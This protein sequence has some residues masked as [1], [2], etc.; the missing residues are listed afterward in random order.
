MKIKI[1]ELKKDWEQDYSDIRLGHRRSRL[2]EL[3]WLYGKTKDKYKGYESREDAK[4]LLQI[5]DHIKKE[6]DGDL[7]INGKIQ[8]DIEQTINLQIQIEMIK[9]FNITAFIIAKIAGKLNINPLFLMSRL[10]HSHYAKFTGFAAANKDEMTEAEIYSPTS[11]VYNWEE[12]VNS[13]TILVQRDKELMQLPS[14]SDAVIITEERN[15]EDVKGNIGAKSIIQIM[16]EKVEAEKIK[17]QN[18]NEF[19]VKREK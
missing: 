7:V 2:D 3:S 19:P 18:L 9:E 11:I 8:V 1:D 4:L 6:V 16:M 14:I 13:N 15:G 10:A 5:L 12:I 17:F